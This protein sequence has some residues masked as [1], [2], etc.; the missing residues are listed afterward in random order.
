MAFQKPRVQPQF[1]DLKAILSQTQQDNADYQVLQTL[2]ERLTQYQRVINEELA[3]KGAG[4]PGTKGDKGDK[5]DPGT[6]VVIK[7]SVPDSGSLPPT[8]NTP[9]DGYITEDDGHLWVWDGTAWVDAGLIQGPPGPTGPQGPIGPAGP[10]STVPGP[11]G[12]TGATGPPGSTGAQGPQGIQGPI[13]PEGP[14][15]DTGDTGPPAG[16][17]QATHQIGGG[18]TLLNNAWTNQPNVFTQKQTITT[19]TATQLE[20]TGT[21]HPAIILNNPSEIANE[22][23]ARVYH[24]QKLIHFDFPNDAENATSGP[25]VTINRVGNIDA[26]GVIK[27]YA[28]ESLNYIVATNAIQTA[29]SFISTSSEGLYIRGTPAARIHLRETA[30]PSGSQTYV[31]LQTQQV[32]AFAPTDDDGITPVGSNWLRSLSIGRTGQVRTGA[33]GL[34]VDQVNQGGTG[35]N[36]G[37]YTPS[38]GGLANMATLVIGPAQFIRVGNVVTVSGKV[39]ASAVVVGN[40]CQIRLAG[41]VNSNFTADHQAG[42]SIASAFGS[43]GTVFA[44]PANT[45][46]LRW[47]SV[48]NGVEPLFYQY[49][50]SV[51]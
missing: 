45:I 13:G 22:K 15:G 8:G 42:G 5:G 44:G 38:G 27:G 39:D 20:L 14:K 28:L 3:T 24:Y 31:L 4:T 35:L 19:S 50:Y 2:I 29:G 18:D 12:S 46:E 25:G 9:G 7:G 43:A 21:P 1:A 37:N 26:N 48:H 6:G 34:L 36:W 23:K 32:L 49:T 51:V 16:P 17:H 10:A 33:G 47:K 40:V 30:Q 41:P 11:P